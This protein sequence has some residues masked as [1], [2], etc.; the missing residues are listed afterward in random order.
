MVSCRTEDPNTVTFS[1]NSAT[2]P[3]G[4]LIDRYAK[5]SGK[6]HNACLG[7]GGWWEIISAPGFVPTRTTFPGQLVARTGYD[8]FALN[9][10]K[11]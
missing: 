10:V 9:Q 11:H 7:S 6:T 8:P 5:S 3:M 4:S 2:F 1:S